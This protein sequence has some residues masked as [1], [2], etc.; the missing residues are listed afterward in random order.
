[1]QDYMV[2]VYQRYFQVMSFFEKV[3]DHLQ[4]KQ[5]E[6][7]RKELA[8]ELW[9][10]YADEMKVYNA[11]VSDCKNQVQARRLAYIEEMK[12]WEQWKLCA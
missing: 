5:G 2:M 8:R 7:K 10:K 4:C 12:D 6:E 11:S 3:R 1:M 9:V